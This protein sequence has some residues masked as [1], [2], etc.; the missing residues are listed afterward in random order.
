[1]VIEVTED[2]R[3]AILM[4]LAW[5]AVER[6]GWDLYLAEIALKMD[7]P[8]STKRRQIEALAHNMGDRVPVGKPVLFERLKKLRERLKKLRA[9]TVGQT[10]DLAEANPTGQPNYREL[11]RLPL[12]LEASRP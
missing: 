12:P 9:E 4:G 11:P 2:E 1:M 5:I 7:V 10:P 8:E 3:Q 6:P